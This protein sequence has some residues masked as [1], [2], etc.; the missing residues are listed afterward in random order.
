MFPDLEGCPKQLTPSPNHCTRESQPR[1][2]WLSH[3]A[4]HCPAKGV[5][6]IFPYTG[7]LPHSSRR[8]R[9]NWP[10]LGA[11]GGETG[12]QDWGVVL[13]PCFHL[14]TPCTLTTHTFLA[15]PVPS[16]QSQCLLPPTH[17]IPSISSP[18]SGLPSI[19]AALEEPLPGSGVGGARVGGVGTGTGEGPGSTGSPLLFP[20]AVRVSCT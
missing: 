4:T 11:G 5:T 19:S 2:T 16:P 10:W 13:I 8:G 12:S 6:R 3:L 18:L 20:G 7:V 9:I 14:H 15:H 1:F 17:K